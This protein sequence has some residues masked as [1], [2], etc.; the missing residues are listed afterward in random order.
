MR[1][2]PPRA[3]AAAQVCLLLED[4]IGRHASPLVSDLAHL[5]YFS[6]KNLKSTP[7]AEEEGSV[8]HHE[9]LLLFWTN[10][11]E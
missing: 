4:L 3:L 8:F 10:N 7:Y 5:F 1:P 9:Y 6:L 11:H 2:G